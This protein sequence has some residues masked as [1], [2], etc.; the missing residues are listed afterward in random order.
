MALGL[1]LVFVAAGLMGSHTPKPVREEALQPMAQ[2]Y[3]GVLPCADCAGID[4]SLFL[5]ENGTFILQH[6]YQ[7]DRPGNRVFAI[8][9]KWARTVDKLVL[10][11]VQ[12]EKSYFRPLENGLEM[13]DRDGAP[14]VS[15]NT[16]RLT[17]IKV[18][19][20]I[21]PMA[22]RGLYHYMADAAVFADCFTGV[23]YPVVNNIVME[24]RYL[25]VRKSSGDEVL[26]TFSAHF[27]VV[28]SMEEGMEVKSLVPSSAPFQMK[29]QDHCNE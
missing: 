7:T 9:G 20:P 24:K 6:H 18:Q 13:L 23:T 10:T 17:A 15:S 12:G 27:A 1:L 29:G 28:P 21:T 25:Q 22:M 11:D 4:T 19:L 16:Y 26:L 5:A 8:Y 2:S 3:R 14:I